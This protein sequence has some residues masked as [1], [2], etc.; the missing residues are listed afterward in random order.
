VFPILLTES[1]N[2]ADEDFQPTAK[3]ITH[4]LAKMNNSL[5]TKAPDGYKS[6]ATTRKAPVTPKKRNVPKE[7]DTDSSS[8]RSKDSSGKRGKESDP[9][10]FDDDDDDDEEVGDFAPPCAKFEIKHELD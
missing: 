9:F 6:A 5:D 4:R 2:L 1:K 10:N 7:F 3:A 8:K